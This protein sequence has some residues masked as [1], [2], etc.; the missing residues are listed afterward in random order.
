M[1]HLQLALARD[2]SIALPVDSDFVRKMAFLRLGNS[3]QM[4]YN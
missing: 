3:L 2:N 1:T 4:F